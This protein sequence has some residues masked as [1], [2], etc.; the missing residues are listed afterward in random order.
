MGG[1][2]LVRE[3]SLL[4]LPRLIAAVLALGLASAAPANA[5]VPVQAIE[6]RAAYPHDT[7]AFTEGLFYLAGE[8][9]ESTGY[10]GQSNIR[11]VRIKDG[12]VLQSRSIAPNLFGEASSTGAMRS[13]A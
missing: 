13:S 10:E 9:Y 8:L 7:K 5:A 4:T 1:P 2:V 12:V 11:R 6:V 3:P